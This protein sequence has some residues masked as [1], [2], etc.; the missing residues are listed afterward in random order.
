MRVPQ[1]SASTAVLG[2]LVLLAGSALPQDA[3]KTV[4]PKPESESKYYDQGG[5][6]VDGIAYFTA[7]DKP[8]EF[9]HVAAFDVRSL[10]KLR[11]YRFSQTYDSTPLLFQKKDGTWLIIAHEYKKART[12][13][14][15]RE[16]P[17]VQWIS[18]ANQPG[19]LFFGY[20]YYQHK[21]GSKTILAACQNGL[22][23]LCGESGED[24]WWIKHGSS[25]GVTPCVDQDKGWVF[26]QG[27]GKLFKIRAADGKILKSV[28]VRQPNGCISWNTVLVNDSHG[29]FVATRWYGKPQW[30]S[31]LRVYD[32]E[33]KLVWEKTG[34][35]I[36]KKTT[37]TY[38]EGK[39]VFG[40]GN[41][42][43]KKYKGDQWK[44]VVAY[45]ITDGNIVWK[46]DASEFD[47]SSIMNVPY[48]NGHFYAET[49]QNGP[50]ASRI[51]RIRASD[52]RLEEV[53]DYGHPISSC[54]QCIIGRGTIL[55]GD[56][57]QHRLVA[58]KIAENSQADWPGPFGD[59]QTNQMA[60]PCEP[61]ARLVPMKEIGRPE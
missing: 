1:I 42:W 36:G 14:I 59:P 58:T 9:P 26:F 12:V 43:S 41:S 11:T 34:L 33:L 60:L 4:N 46:Y 37:L 54:G 48:F 53:L 17:E 18:A 49:Q 8:G 23:G 55:S 61:E 10:R 52:G 35:P 19:A 29:R 7:S 38:A 45:S 39:L 50:Q 24:L 30:D 44:Y 31:A 20:S 27:N 28:D 2:A 16:T 57:H 32:E 56:L 6:V 47:F 13:A 22:H 40:G 3:A 51:L 5:V 15:G 21:D 25:G